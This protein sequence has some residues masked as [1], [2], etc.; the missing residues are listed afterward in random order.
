MTASG[1][2]V[3]ASKYEAH[4]GLK[5]CAR[6]LRNRWTQLKSL[7]GWYRWAEKHTGTSKRADGSIVADD[8]WWDKHAKVLSLLQC[9][10][11][12]FVLLIM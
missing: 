11:V 10:L 7:Y 8:A 6:Q 4:T 2:E 1:Y 12:L 9:S 3:M 5:H